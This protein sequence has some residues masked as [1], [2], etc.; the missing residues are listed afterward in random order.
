MWNQLIKQPQLRT[1]NF[2]NYAAGKDPE[3]SSKTSSAKTTLVETDTV[4]RF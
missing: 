1:Q 4:F 3:I 2:E